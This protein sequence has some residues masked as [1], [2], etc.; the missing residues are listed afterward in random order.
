MSF[1]PL[2]KVKVKGSP[3]SPKG[4]WLR[5]HKPGMH[6]RNAMSGDVRHER[7]DGSLKILTQTDNNSQVEGTQLTLLGWRASLLRLKA[8]ALRLEAIAIR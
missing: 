5:V 4:S 2:Y 7:V 3:N 1:S 8:I 6:G